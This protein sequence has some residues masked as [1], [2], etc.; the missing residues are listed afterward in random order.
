MHFNFLHLVQ[1]TGE[2]QIIFSLISSFPFLLKTQQQLGLSWE[3][4]SSFPTS[5][6]RSVWA[7][8]LFQGMHLL[9]PQPRLIAGLQEV[10]AE[11]EGKLF[12]LLVQRSSELVC[13]LPHLGLILGII[14]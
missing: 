4:E 7:H 10:R 13:P 3:L 11:A 6:R 1:R 12:V 2:V 5:Q 8:P 9:Q 14:I